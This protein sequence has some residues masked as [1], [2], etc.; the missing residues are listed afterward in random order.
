MTHDSYSVIRLYTSCEKMPNRL[1]QPNSVSQREKPIYPSIYLVFLSKTLIT[2]F[3]YVSE[4]S[5]YN[6]PV[7]S[8]QHDK[9]VEEET[10]GWGERGGEGRGND[11][12]FH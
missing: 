11:I 6:V 5:I 9:E 12:S 4:R 10:R 7:K 3:S 2:T 8:V 1:P